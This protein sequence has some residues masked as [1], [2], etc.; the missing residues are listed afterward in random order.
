MQWVYVKTINLANLDIQEENIGLHELSDGSE[1]NNIS[2]SKIMKIFSSASKRGTLFE[3]F[4]ILDLREDRLI[5]MRRTSGVEIKL[6]KINPNHSQGKRN[7]RNKRGRG[8]RRGVRKNYDEEYNEHYKRRG[9]KGKHSS[10]DESYDEDF[11]RKSNNGKRREN[12]GEEGELSKSQRRE[13]HKGR[14]NKREERRNRRGD[15]AEYVPRSLLENED[16]QEEVEKE[17]RNGNGNRFRRSNPRRGR[18]GRNRGGRNMKRGSNRG[19]GQWVKKSNLK[20]EEHVDDMEQKEVHPRKH[21]GNRR[22]HKIR[23][24][25]RKQSYTVYEKKSNMQ[26]KDE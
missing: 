4:P 20:T 10:H 19:G 24:G 8:G 14:K 5:E 13:N 11:R 2:G 9:R 7:Y 1:I 6:T 12:R 3:I 15:D 22:G 23:R 25:G 21:N 16:A 26:N 18:G 17:T